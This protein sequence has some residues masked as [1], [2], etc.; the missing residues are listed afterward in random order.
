MPA[1]AMNPQQRAD[2]RFVLGLVAAVAVLSTFILGLRIA[3]AASAG[4]ARTSLSE[5]RPV[6][7]AAH[8]VLLSQRPTV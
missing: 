4:P 7:T 6:Q 8:H 3:R 2:L 1:A 5:S